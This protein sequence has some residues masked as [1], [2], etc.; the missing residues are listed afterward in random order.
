MMGGD[1]FDASMATFTIHQWADL[2]RGRAEMRRVTRGPVVL[3]TSDPA[4]LGVPG[5]PRR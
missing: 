5:M 4:A 3:L 1:S 2:Q